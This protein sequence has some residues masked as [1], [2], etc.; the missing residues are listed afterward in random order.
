MQL[1]LE[2]VAGQVGHFLDAWAFLRSED[3]PRK[4][5]HEFLCFVMRLGPRHVLSF[6]GG[7]HRPALDCFGLL[8]AA[9]GCLGLFRIALGCFGLRCFVGLLVGSVVGWLVG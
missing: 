7:L 3:V 4:M 5:K 9:L 2:P 6:S 8:R 1:S